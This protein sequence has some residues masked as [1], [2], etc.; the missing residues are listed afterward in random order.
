[1]DR[2]LLPK[3]L[4]QRLPPWHLLIGAP[5]TFLVER[6]LHCVCHLPPLESFFILSHLLHVCLKIGTSILETREKSLFTIKEY[7]IVRDVASSDAIRNRCWYRIV[8]LDVLFNAFWLDFDDLCE[9]S[10]CH[11]ES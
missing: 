11:S 2:S 3:D 6:S 5:R 9:S 4:L 1:M 8:N 7:G 10:G